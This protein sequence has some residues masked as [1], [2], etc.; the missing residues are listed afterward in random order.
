M[1]MKK[2]SWSEK[3]FDECDYDYECKCDFEYEYECE[4]ECE[5]GKRKKPP[6]SRI[7]KGGRITRFR[8]RLVG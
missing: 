7:P 1:T 8:E 3:S 4:C 5:L 2:A 6:E